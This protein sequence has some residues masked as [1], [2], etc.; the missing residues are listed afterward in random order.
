MDE[1]VSKC[2]AK[3]WI[4]VDLVKRGVLYVGQ[5]MF[6]QK[7]VKYATQPT[8]MKVRLLSGDLTRCLG[9]RQAGHRFCR[10]RGEGAGSQRSWHGDVAEEGRDPG[11]VGERVDPGESGPVG[12]VGALFLQGLVASE[13]EMSRED[14]HGVEAHGPGAAVVSRGRT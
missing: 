2:K 12:G 10:E 1:R 11:R 13:Q 14:G 6:A 9:G 3:M 5:D 4:G 7:G 8:V